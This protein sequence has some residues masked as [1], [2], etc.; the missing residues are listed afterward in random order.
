MIAALEGL[1]PFDSPDKRKLRKIYFEA[2]AKSRTT[3][4]HET[5]SP[6]LFG[7]NLQGEF[8][9]SGLDV[10]CRQIKGMMLDMP[11]LVDEAHITAPDRNGGFHLC[12][13]EHS[14]RGRVTQICHNPATG[15]WIGSFHPPTRVEEKKLSSFFPDAVKSPEDIENLFKGASILAKTESRLLWQLPEAPFV[16][17]ACYREGKTTISTL[18]PILFYGEFAPDQAMQIT[19]SLTVSSEEVLGFAQ[20]GD[21]R[22][23]IGPDRIVDIASEIPGLGINSGVYIRIPRMLLLRNRALSPTE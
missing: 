17:E 3:P 15:V 1:E 8:E 9:E 2:M 7:R 16:V 19:V 13:P 11:A 18:Y 21:L 4:T 12:P 14:L 10:L 6:I 5:S 23:A 20:A 22:Y